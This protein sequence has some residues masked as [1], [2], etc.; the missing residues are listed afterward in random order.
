[1][2]MLDHQRIWGEI[3]RSEKISCE[4]I[5]DVPVSANLVGIEAK[6]LAYTEFDFSGPGTPKQ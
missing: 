4:F 1:M 3:N 6:T 5:F 2:L